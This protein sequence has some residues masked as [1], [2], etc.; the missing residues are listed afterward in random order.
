[1]GT[2]S[3]QYRPDNSKAFVVVEGFF[4]AH[5]GGNQDRDDDVA[6]LFSG[7]GT[8]YTPHRLHHIDLGIPGR[9]K[10]NG[11]QGRYVHPFGK[12]A[13]IRQNTTLIAI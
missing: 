12:T 1:M 9:Q 11:I 13:H 6:K 8:H 7:S 4:R 10:E 5:I 3:V 2:Q